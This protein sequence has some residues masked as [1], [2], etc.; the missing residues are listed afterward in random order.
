MTFH[1]LTLCYITKYQEHWKEIRTEWMIV[2]D[3]LSLTSCH[4]VDITSISKMQNNSIVLQR[5]KF[6]DSGLFITVTLGPA[7]IH[8]LGHVS[9]TQCFSHPS[10][11]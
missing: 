3:Y 1:L 10:C 9:D 11:I 4:I 5:V 6:C 2:S 8:C 7:I